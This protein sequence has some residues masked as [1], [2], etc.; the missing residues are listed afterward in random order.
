MSAVVGGDGRAVIHNRETGQVLYCSVPT[1]LENV[2]NSN[3]VWAHGEGDGT[4]VAPAAR[5]PVAVPVEP[6][7]QLTE[8]DV[9]PLPLPA[10]EPDPVP[11]AAVDAEPAQP[12]PLDHDGDGKKGGSRKPID[13]ER[14]AVI[15]TLKANNI[16]FF[17]GWSTDKLKA[18]L[19]A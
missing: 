12:D 6:V 2:A 18:L 11:Q 19:P 5:A 16:K 4:T 3:G 7:I 15:A 1:A 13:P 9:L 10:A 14:A 17:V 8:P